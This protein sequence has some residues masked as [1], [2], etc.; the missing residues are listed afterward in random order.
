MPEFLPRVNASRYDYADRFDWWQAAAELAQFYGKAHRLR[1]QV[2]VS[3]MEHYLALCK[4]NKS[5][6]SK[7]F[8]LRCIDAWCDR[9]MSTI[10]RLI[11]LIEGREPLE[12]KKPIVNEMP[13]KGRVAGSEAKSLKEV[14]PKTPEE[15]LNGMPVAIPKPKAF[16][17][18]AGH[19][20]KE[21]AIE[22]MKQ[23]H[24]ADIELWEEEYFVFLGV[25]PGIGNIYQLRQQ[26]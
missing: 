9:D 17:L 14:M 6:P 21:S 12:F 15:F 3:A 1:E 18:K 23:Y 2:I 24:P 25:S 10:S 11:S 19:Y 22:W 20:T 8:F 26:R 4:E 16:R 7:E 5:E 13:G